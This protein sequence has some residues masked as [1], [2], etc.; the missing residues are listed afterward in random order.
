LTRVNPGVNVKAVRL[1]HQVWE[2]LAVCDSQGN[3]VL[4]EELAGL[5]ESFAASRRKILAFLRYSIPHDGPDKLHMYR[6]KIDN[7]LSEFIL[8]RFRVLWFRE[9]SGRVVVCTSMFMKKTQATPEHEKTRARNLRRA[10]LE[11]KRDQRLTVRD[12]DEE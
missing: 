11:A 9:E 7:E 3:C 4:L 6:D 2:V 12:L 10:Y 1:G 8:G 5:N